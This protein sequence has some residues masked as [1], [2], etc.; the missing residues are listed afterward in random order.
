M[1]SKGSLRQIRTAIGKA[2]TK[3]ICPICDFNLIFYLKFYLFVII[4]YLMTKIFLL[5]LEVIFDLDLC[6]LMR[7][8]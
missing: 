1:K 8:V 5:L 7:N 4:I 6:S 3:P 2:N